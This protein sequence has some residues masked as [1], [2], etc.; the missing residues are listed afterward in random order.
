MCSLAL[1]FTSFIQRP[2][3]LNIVGFLL[4][5]AAIICNAFFGKAGEGSNDL[6]DQ[7]DGDR[8]QSESSDKRLS[9]IVNG[10]AA[11]SL[12][13]LFSVFLCFVCSHHG[14]DGATTR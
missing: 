7:S 13:T 9:R 4:F 12:L 11:R 2:L 14:S 6:S 3:I 10:K 1:F 8:E 5:F